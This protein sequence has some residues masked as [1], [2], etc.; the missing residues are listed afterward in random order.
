MDYYKSLTKVAGIP[1]G[2]QTEEFLFTIKMVDYFFYNKNIGE[3]DVR[4]CFIDGAGDGGI[5]YIFFT[6][7]MLYLIQGKSSKKISPEE[8]S[9]A[10]KKMATTVRDFQSNNIDRYSKKT[11]MA[12]INKY[13]DLDES[14]NISLVLFTAA[15]LDDKIRERI[16]E[17]VNEPEL[18]DYD[19]KVY[20]NINFQD[21][22]YILDQQKE[23][24]KQDNIKL[25]TKDFL[26][27]NENGVIFNIMASSLKDLYVKH[28][29]Q[30]LFGYN[31]RDHI[32]DKRVDTAIDHTIE[33]ER[34]NFWFYNNGITI[35]CHDFQRDGDVLRLYGFSIINGAQTTTKIGNSKI[36]SKENDFPLVC[37][38]VKASYKDASEA[39][40][41][42]AMRFIE[43]I[44]EASNSQKPIKPRDLKANSREQKQLQKNSANNI[45]YDLSIL[46][47]RGVEPGNYKS[48][49]IKNEKWR[50]VTNEDIG[51]LILALLLQQPGSARNAKSKLFNSEKLYNK[52]YKRRAHDYNILFDIVRLQNMYAEFRKSFPYDDPTLSEDDKLEY[53]AVADNGRLVVLAIIFFFY[54]KMAKI[55]K[56]P[57]DTRLKEDNI[58]KTKLTLDYKGDD[59]EAKLNYL[60][61]WI[62]VQLRKIYDEKKHDLKLTSYSNFFKSDDYYSEIILAEFNRLFHDQYDK[63]RILGY[64]DVFF[65]E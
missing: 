53:S 42:K 23:L 21:Q 47:K 27:Y 28:S 5:D 12:Y 55:I 3:Q 48:T 1:T 59:F 10:L 14:K 24:V 17:I 57:E 44:S 62:I 46:I 22:M 49:N 2:K 20:D 8:I 39:D 35:G 6:E 64:M 63:D 31:L 18:S 38:V 37:K 11:K 7:E 29:S 40:R 60:F 56:G 65:N 50:R 61:K 34:E 25:Y 32:S 41:E 15:E 36:V 13:A 58:Q 16:K 45:P 43:T 19:I 26:E 4:D 30:G 54:K 33:R 51:Q 52:I 9:N